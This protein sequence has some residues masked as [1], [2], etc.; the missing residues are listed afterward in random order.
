[1]SNVNSFGARSTL[2]TASGPVYIYSLLALEH[3][4]FPGISRLPFSLKILL[5]TSCWRTAASSSRPTSKRWPRGRQEHDVSRNLFHAGARAPAGLHRRA[6][7]RRSRGDAR[8]IARL[9]GDPNKV[10]P[11][12]PV[13]LVTDHSVQVD[14]FGQETHLAER[15]TEFTA[16]QG[17]PRSCAGARARFETSASFRRTPIVHQVNLEHSL[18]SS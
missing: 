8:R 6:L 2:S 4:G 10:N 16:Q 1:M 13:E 11:L 3:R 7:C 5:R 12:Q 15:R 18:A 9:G 17:T 14:Y